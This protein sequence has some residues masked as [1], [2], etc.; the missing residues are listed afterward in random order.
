MAKIIVNGARMRCTL[1]TTEAR[2]G[3]TSHTFVKVGGALVAT[4]TDKEP[5]V[6]I[7]TFG[8]CKCGWPNSLCI[9]QPQRW[10]QTAQSSGVKVLSLKV[11][12]YSFYSLSFHSF[13]I[14]SSFH[15]LN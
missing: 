2:I 6:N 14:F 3:V 15:F 9:P 10:Q 1:G 13:F 8:T 11:C 5:M 4:E 12:K 7:P